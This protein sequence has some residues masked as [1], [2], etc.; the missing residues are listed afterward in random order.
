MVAIYFVTNW[1]SCN[2][3]TQYAPKGSHNTSLLDLSRSS[4]VVLSCKLLSKCR[5]DTNYWLMTMNTHTI[6]TFQITTCVPKE[7]AQCKIWS[8]NYYNATDILFINN[9]MSQIQNQ[10][11]LFHRALCCRQLLRQK[12]RQPSP[13]SN[14]DFLISDLSLTP[15]LDFSILTLYRDFFSLLP[16]DSNSRQRLT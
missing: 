8:P 13:D 5:S 1:L 6:I 12:S 9:C 3:L 2:D 10:T 7:W 4:P 15:L 11:L 16:L 14:N